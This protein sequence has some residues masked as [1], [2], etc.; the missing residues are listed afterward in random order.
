MN[1]K[2]II[3]AVLSL[4]MAAGITACTK[5][6]KAGEDIEKV[7]DKYEDALKKFDV[8][9]ALKLTSFEEGEDG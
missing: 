5:S 9:K 6:K 8:D 7:I 3:A 2:R 4:S 1:T